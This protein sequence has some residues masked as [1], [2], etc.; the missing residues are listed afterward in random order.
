VPQSKIPSQTLP[1]RMQFRVPP[2]ASRLLRARDR[3]RD[4]L[5]Q[6]CAKEELVDD[7]V[8]CIEEA[9][10]NAIRHSGTADDIEISLQFADCDLVALVRDSGRGFDVAGFD[11]STPPEPTLDGGRGLFLISQLSDVLDL[12]CDGGLEV[13]TVMRGVARRDASALESGL[14]ETITA[15]GEAHRENRLRAML[16][17]IDE[18]FVAL[19]WDYRFVHANESACRMVGRSCAEL[20]GQRLRDLWPGF[21]ETSAGGA[22]RE[23]M[24]LGRPSVVEFGTV[25]GAGWLEAR[26][27]PTP[28]GVSVYLREINERKRVEAEL[29]ESEARYR[30]L[31]ENMLDGYAYCRMIYEDGVPADF[32]YLDVNT[33]FE[34]LTGLADVVGRKVSEVIPG[35]RENNPELFEIYGRVAQGGPPESFEVHI[36]ALDIWLS[37]S[38]YS[39]RADHFVAV[40]E[41]VSERRRAEDERRRLLEESKEAARLSVALNEIDAVIHSTLRVE[42]I[43]QRV[44]ASAVDAVGSDSAMVALRRG[45]DWVAEYGHPE[46]PGV[47]HESVRSDEVPFMMTAVAERRLVAIDDCETDARCIPEVQRRFGVRSV[48]CMPLIAK[49]EVLGVVFFN[50]HHA[51][52]HFSEQTLDFAGKLAAA[53]SSAL[54]NAR[55]YEEQRRIATTLQENFLHPLPSVAGLELGVVSHAAYE[56][57]LVGGDFSDVFLLENGQVAIL[58][59]DV[60]GKGVRAAGLTETVRSTVRAFAAID[61]APAFVLR[62]TN[63]LLLRYD[64]DEPHVTAFLCVLDPHTGHITFASA[65]HPAPIRVG[66]YS[67]RPLEVP[68]GPPLGTFPGDYD[69]AHAMLTL[70]DYLVLYTDGVVEARR[71]DELFGEGQLLEVSASL[72]GRTA[73]EL[74]EAVLEAVVAFADRLRDDLQVVTMRLA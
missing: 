18:A 17:E 14:G 72:Q 20:L 5:R 1:P 57:E 73:Q 71:G 49:D 67:S 74:A 50:H 40:F 60:A 33:A 63:E 37:V 23:A 64:P 41:N 56:P 10:T 9:C 65:G 24:E 38:A 7:V 3:V 52:V 46:V 54:E 29:R 4:Y 68:N 13:R 25:D 51:A 16:E 44:V 34:R 6:Y 69:T 21:A 43:M 48:L 35:V 61:P 27:Y 30:S 47:I 22:V 11:P 53:I 70:E 66:P 2:E 31:F 42:E 8:L 32:V 59:G 26:V 28:A 36:E 55:L 19:D 15:S 39:P 62:K 45:E 58:I 12:R